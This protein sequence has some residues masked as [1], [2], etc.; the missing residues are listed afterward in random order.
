M[1]AGKKALG[2]RNF[3]SVLVL[4]GAGLVGVQVCRQIAHTFS[5]RKI[6]VASLL[7]D[8]ARDAIAHLGRE[9]GEIE[10][11]PVWGNLFV[12]S[13]L[14]ATPPWEIG[15]APELRE[16]I[17]DH[18]Y[19]PIDQAYPD[20]HM[21]RIIEDHRPGVIVDCV[22]TATGISYQNVTDG[23][24]KVRAR[25]DSGEL[26]SAGGLSDVETLLMSQSNPQ[27]VR[28]VLF[29][30]R[31]TRAVGTQFYVKVGTTGTGG[32]GLNIPYTHGEDKPSP[33]LMAKNAVG[34]AHSGLLFAMART[35]DAPIVKEV[36]PAAMIGYRAVTYKHVKQKGINFRLFEPRRDLLD[37]GGS[38]VETRESPDS[39]EEL[40]PLCTTVVDTG[41]N[42]LFTRGEFA[43][44]TALGQM[45]VVTPEEV[46]RA[47]VLEL[48][49][50]NSGKDI[51]SALDAAVLGP[52]YRA[53]L[54]RQV[55]LKDLAGLE[56]QHSDHSV[57]L[58]L[59]GPPELSKLLFEVHILAR[60]FGGSRT[61]ILYA[62]DDGG[63]ERT[64]GEVVERVAAFMETEAG[65]E[66]GRMAISVGVPVLFADGRTLL[67]GP[68]LNIPQPQGNETG[69]SLD[70]QGRL[71]SW[72]RKG[73][74][75]L[76]VSNIQLWL[77][78]FR[79]MARGR[80]QVF[81]QGTAG[82]DIKTYIGGDV[83]EIGNA[84]A[85]I[86]NNELEGYR[87]K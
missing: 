54:M 44:I 58:G 7:E 86:F 9:H 16:Q 72:A 70:D 69:F 57:A 83:F 4:G 42:G 63:R 18:I 85:W 80:E 33:V 21:V 64:P 30:Y 53:G 43:A 46:A 8:E 20:N 71:D 87:L 23:V 67:R 47:V 62:D 12:P 17:L 2:G 68:K 22:N 10:F 34:F 81:N 31:A 59:L 82:V 37:P 49:G 24:H 35:P 55:A 6:V 32:M 26:S 61:D 48:C 41:E 25:I 5:P 78:R 52:T 51:I 15:G 40:G 1:L 75:D 36:K 65:R 73:W 11:V 28:H 77:E 14:A 29:L 19:G 74:V 27:L 84:V 56:E 50:A 60:A 79:S 38:K 39:Y 66:I 13:S 3:D 45:E 76:R